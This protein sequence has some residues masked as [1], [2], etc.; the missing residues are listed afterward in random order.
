MLSETKTHF[1]LYLSFAGIVRRNC[2]HNR[3]MIFRDAY[4]VSHDIMMYDFSSSLAYVYHPWVTTSPILFLPIVFKP[5]TKKPVPTPPGA[6]PTLEP[7]PI[8]NY[9][10]SY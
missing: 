6:V 4:F 1:L 2:M 5:P 7:I 9:I 3:F 10:F 8:P